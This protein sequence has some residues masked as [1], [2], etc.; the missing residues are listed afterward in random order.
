MHANNW[1]A[2]ERG[3]GRWGEGADICLSLS[4]LPGPV[5]TQSA[6]K[7]YLNTSPSEIWCC[8][9]LWPLSAAQLARA[10]PTLASIMRT[11]PL[12][13]INDHWISWH[14]LTLGSI[15]LIAYFSIRLQFSFLLRSPWLKVD[16]NDSSVQESPGPALSVKISLSGGS[17]GER[18]REGSDSSEAWTADQHLGQ[19]TWMEGALV[20]MGDSNDS[21]GKYWGGWTQHTGRPPPWNIAGSLLLVVCLCRTTTT[22]CDKVE[23]KKLQVSHLF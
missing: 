2:S 10:H 9:Q 4:L 12:L 17:Q 20:L 14:S 7:C 5:L 19:N 13:V 6:G 21:R 22:K 1:F 16:S 23:Q 18:G 3:G 11:L 15:F 8:C